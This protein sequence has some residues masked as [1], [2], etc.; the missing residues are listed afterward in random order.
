LV[1]DSWFLPENGRFAEIAKWVYL[2]SMKKGLLFSLIALALCFQACKPEEQLRVEKVI[3]AYD[4][5]ASCEI[6]DLIQ[7]GNPTIVMDSAVVYV[8]RAV[9]D[10]NGFIEVWDEV[11]FLTKELGFTASRTNYYLNGQFDG[12][13]GLIIQTDIVDQQARTRTQCTYT[14]KAQ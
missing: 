9:D 10:E 12:A 6:Y 7:Q 2:A 11:V 3:G 14:C 5:T 1:A 13:G 8:K 4:Y